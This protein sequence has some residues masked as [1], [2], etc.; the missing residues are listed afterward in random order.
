MFPKAHRS[1]SITLGN[2]LTACAGEVRKCHKIVLKVSSVKLV[3][4][5]KMLRQVLFY[6]SICTKIHYILSKNVPLFHQVTQY[7]GFH[8]FLARLRIH[9]YSKLV[10]RG[11]TFVA[12]RM[13][14]ELTKKPAIA[15]LTQVP[16]TNFGKSRHLWANSEF[17]RLKLW[18]VSE[19]IQQSY[20][21]LNSGITV[22]WF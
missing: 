18:W 3:S 15:T 16:P 12:G 22:P 6:W 4:N 11:F 19:F 7:N 13:Q 14:M 2:F 21:W 17:I 10:S 8:I 1:N 20:T 5:L 9:Y